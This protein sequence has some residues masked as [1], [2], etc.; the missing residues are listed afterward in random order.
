MLCALNNFID[1]Y[2]KY[3]MGSPSK[4]GGLNET[5]KNERTPSWYQTR[6][7][8]N[9]ETQEPSYFRYTRDTHALTHHKEEK[10]QTAEK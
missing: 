10:T 8:M 4:R 2:R 7:T 5:E 6:E 3:A 1:W 9:G